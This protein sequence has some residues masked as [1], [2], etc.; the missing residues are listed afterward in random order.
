MLPQMVIRQ[1]RNRFDG[2]L[3]EAVAKRKQRTYAN[4][5]A[6]ELRAGIHQ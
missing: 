6:E 1:A 2:F 5:A 3:A 4:E